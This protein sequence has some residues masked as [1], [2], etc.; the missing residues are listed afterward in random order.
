MGYKSFAINLLINLIGNLVY[1]GYK[2]VMIIE[3]NI[4]PSFFDLKTQLAGNILQKFVQ[5]N[6]KLV[7][8]GDFNKYNSKSLH[9]FINESNKSDSINFKKFYSTGFRIIL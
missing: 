2:K 9:E 7:I 3:E 1:Q 6:L 8:I 4:I 5:Y